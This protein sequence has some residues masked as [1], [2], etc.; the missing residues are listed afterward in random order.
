M[1]LHPFESLRE[2][3]RLVEELLSPAN[4]EVVEV[5]S[6]PLGDL[7][8]RAWF[9]VTVQSTVAVECA[10][11]KVPCFLC[12]WLANPMFDYAGQ[13]A[14]FGAGAAM[15]SAEDIGGIPEI[16]R[17]WRVSANAKQNLLSAM[18]VESLR[19]IFQPGSGSG[20]RAEKAIALSG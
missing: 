15:G 19:E 9:A 7:V 6:G 8:A 3:R 4:R 5:V 14:R 10:L 2:R 16:V 1:K 12:K 11:Q 20:L 18:P 13:F 17:R